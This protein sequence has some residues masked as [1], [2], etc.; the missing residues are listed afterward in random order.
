MSTNASNDAS[1]EDDDNATN[2]FLAP[3]GKPPRIGDRIGF[4]DKNGKKNVAKVTSQ[5]GKS[6]VIYKFC[7][8]IEEPNGQ[9]KCIDLYRDVE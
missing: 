3:T 5:A 1:D 2:G 6:T 7:F 4:I 9:E 8:N